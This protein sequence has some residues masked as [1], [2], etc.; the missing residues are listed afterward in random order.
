MCPSRCK[1]LKASL[2][3]PRAQS[4]EHDFLVFTCVIFKAKVKEIVY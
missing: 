1:T 2:A 3:V 4:A